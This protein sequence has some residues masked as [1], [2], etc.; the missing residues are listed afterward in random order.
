MKMAENLVWYARNCLSICGTFTWLEPNDK[1]KP[2]SYLLAALPQKH[3]AVDPFFQDPV[4]TGMRHMIKTRKVKAKA[5]NKPI[6]Y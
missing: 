2:C 3:Q 1:L 4:G 6:K 5:E